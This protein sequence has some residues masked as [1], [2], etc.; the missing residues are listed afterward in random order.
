MAEQDFN[1]PNQFGLRSTDFY[2]TK[3]EAIKLFEDQAHSQIS[4]WLGVIE[5][6]RSDIQPH[7]TSF[8]A[9]LASHTM[10]KIKAH[11]LSKADQ[12]E[13]DMRHWVRFLSWNEEEDKDACFKYFIQTKPDIAGLRCSVTAMMMSYPDGTEPAEGGPQL[14]EPFREALDSDEEGLETSPS[15]EESF[16]PNESIR[17]SRLI[18]RSS[19][20]DG[21]ESETSDLGKESSEPS[22][23]L[24]QSDIPIRAVD[25][26]P[27][28]VQT[29]EEPETVEYHLSV[30]A[31]ND[32]SF[33]RMDDALIG[34]LI[35]QFA[36]V[37]SGNSAEAI[38]CV[39]E[40]RFL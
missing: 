10:T 33:L 22:E 36:K 31:Q 30:R 19:E 15:S 12:C 29:K 6:F 38:C 26:I 23:N 4:E 13:A 34:S 5:T 39:S 20:T 14:A 9:E 24:E 11:L 37:G 35:L 27:E 17:E 7:L 18:E 40:K 21:E 16:E 28:D 25:R 2:A 3:D 1:V 8:H 32:F